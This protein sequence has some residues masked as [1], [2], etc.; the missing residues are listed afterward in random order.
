VYSIHSE[1]S[2]ECNG[3]KSDGTCAHDLHVHY[4]S[5]GYLMSPKRSETCQDCTAMCHM[6][7]HQE[8]HCHNLALM[9][10]ARL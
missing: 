1:T 2:M 7:T 5:H 10:A 4:V 6:R 3:V 8:V 9:L